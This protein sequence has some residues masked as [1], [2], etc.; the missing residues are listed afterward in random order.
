MQLLLLEP[1]YL[2]PVL[3]MVLL[4]AGS[5]DLLRLLSCVRIGRE[6]LAQ[7]DV[8]S[9]LS[10]R[11][12]HNARRRMSLRS[13][14]DLQSAKEGYLRGQWVELTNRYRQV[15]GDSLAFR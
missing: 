1:S 9:G 2:C 14:P 5:E 8:R 4:Q 6:P 11:I 12:H 10:F 15:A 3:T 13:E 7:D